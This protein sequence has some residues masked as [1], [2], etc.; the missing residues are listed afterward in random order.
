[1][2]L[3][4]TNYDIIDWFVNHYATVIPYRIHGKIISNR[5]FKILVFVYDMFFCLIYC[6]KL[7]SFFDYEN[8]LSISA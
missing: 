4:L 1:M 8:F 6:H 7:F 2:G 5:H 3:E